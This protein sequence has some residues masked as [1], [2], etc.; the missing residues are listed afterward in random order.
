[1]LWKDLLQNDLICVE[2]DVINYVVTHSWPDDVK[3]AKNQALVLL[4]LVFSSTGRAFH[5]SW[6][7]FCLCEYVCLDVNRGGTSRNCCTQ[8]LVILQAQ[9]YRTEEP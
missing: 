7:K 1:M 2:V 3:G 8:R 6:S 5:I 9:I 4:D